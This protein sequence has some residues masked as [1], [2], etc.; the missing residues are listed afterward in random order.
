MSFKELAERQSAVTGRLVSTL[1]KGR[2]PHAILFSG[3]PDA[4]QRQAAAELAKALFC[5]NASDSQVCGVC[6][7]CRQVDANTHPDFFTL[8]P[9]DDSRVIKIEEVRAL[10]GR[11]NLKPFQASAKVF[12]I[13]PAECMNDF[14]QNALLKTLEEPPGKTFFILISYASE[15]L[16]PTVRSR[17]QT[18]YFLPPEEMSAGDPELEEDKRL[19]LQGV[20]HG[21]G[22]GAGLSVPD[23][24]KHEREE[25]T[26][27]LDFVIG[28]FREMLLLHEGAGKMVAPSVDRSDREN[29]ASRLG[30]E[31]LLETLEILAEFREKIAESVNL[32]LALS[33]LWETLARV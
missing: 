8:G 20:L 31:R 25:V 2:L 12:V 16:L 26:Q 4:G 15:K 18:F 32:K 9:E 19:V 11:A 27:V 10:I 6:V 17:V 24:S 28:V 3:P 5:E 1:R 29:A 7:H 13:E 14:S 23:L 22:R 21:L 33:V 30:E